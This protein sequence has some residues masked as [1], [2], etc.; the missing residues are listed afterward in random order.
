MSLRLKDSGQTMVVLGIVLLW[1]ISIT[2]AHSATVAERARIHELEAGFRDAARHDKVWTNTWAGIYGGA[3]VAYG[4]V[5]RNA[6]A[7]NDRFDARVSAVK[8][9]L[10]LGNLYLNPL[11]HRPALQRYRA[12]VVNASE[13]ADHLKLA[14]KLREE[15]ARQERDRQG[16]NARM[17]P[18]AV[19]LAAGLT[20]GVVDERPE[21]GAINF[22][23]GMLTSE[24]AIR[25]QPNSMAGYGSPLTVNIGQQQVE[26]AYQWFV[27]PDSVGL[28]LRF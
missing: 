9:A 2:P 1:L 3:A 21:D 6:S 20:I 19:N 11:P 4:L 7:A 5:S 23:M 10:A 24:I 18:F 13:G 26:L 16:L 28:G 15:L 8:S 27:A 22:A 25:T 17:L 12:A 14:E